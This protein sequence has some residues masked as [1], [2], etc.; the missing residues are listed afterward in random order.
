[1]ATAATYSQDPID[2]L[3]AAA[4]GLKILIKGPDISLYEYMSTNSSS[5]PVASADMQQRLSPSCT[6]TSHNWSQIASGQE[7]KSIQPDADAVGS[8]QSLPAKTKA[9]K[10]KSTTEFVPQVDVNHLID[11]IAG[12]STQTSLQLKKARNREAAQLSRE[13]KREE[14]ENLQNEIADKSQIIADQATTIKELSD[15]V[16]TLE[17][18]NGM[19]AITK[20]NLEQRLKRVNSFLMDPKT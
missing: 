3:N 1:M 15:K 8:Q 2:L 10:R 13:R 11:A 19:L 7:E 5:S 6:I 4:G 16:K 18:V 17:Q 12:D 14:F 9:S 20:A